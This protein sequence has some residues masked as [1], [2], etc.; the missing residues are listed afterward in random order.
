MMSIRITIPKGRAS[1]PVPILILILP[2][3]RRRRRA[4]I[5]RS[6][7]TRFWR[8]GTKSRSV[9][10]SLRIGF[11]IRG[12]CRFLPRDKGRRGNAKAGNRSRRVSCNSC[13]AMCVGRI[14]RSSV[15]SRGERRRVRRPR[16][17]IIRR[18]MRR[19]IMRRGIFIVSFFSSFSTEVVLFFA[20]LIC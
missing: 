19:L 14:V 20:F 11:G 13:R 18:V 10:P 7:G 6:G 2:L 12:L 9:G 3:R 8:L 15:M 1:K 5:K 16:W 17:E 4:A